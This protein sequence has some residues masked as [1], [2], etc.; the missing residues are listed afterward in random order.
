MCLDIP[1]QQ[2]TKKYCFSPDNSLN[3]LKYRKV[4]RVLVHPTIYFAADNMIVELKILRLWQDY[5]FS[6]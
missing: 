2:N 5:L 6:L 1:Q 3:Y 4:F